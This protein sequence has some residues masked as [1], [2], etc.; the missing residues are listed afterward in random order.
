MR[1]NLGRQEAQNAVVH[2]VSLQDSFQVR[3]G[4]A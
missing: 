1:A 2:G 4:A 3:Y